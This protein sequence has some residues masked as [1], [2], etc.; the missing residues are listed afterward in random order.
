MQFGDVKR[1]DKQRNVL[2]DSLVERRMRL[3]SV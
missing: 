2:I 3:M 1:G